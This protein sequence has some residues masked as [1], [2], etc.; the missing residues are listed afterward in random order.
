V[1]Q[2]DE[3]VLDVSAELHMGFPL[4]V[5]VDTKQSVRS[6]IPMQLTVVP[7]TGPAR[8]H[9]FMHHNTVEVC[10]HC[11]PVANGPPDQCRNVRCYDTSSGW[12]RVDLPFDFV[13]ESGEYTVILH[14]PG[15]GAR[16]SRTVRVPDALAAG[17]CALPDTLGRYRRAD[18][19]AAAV[20]LGVK[21]QY[22]GLKARYEA[23]HCRLNVFSLRISDAVR[24]VFV[25][26]LGRTATRSLP[27]GRVHQ[28]SLED[29][30]IGTWL[31]RESLIMVAAARDTPATDTVVSDLLRAYP[32][33]ATPPRQVPTCAATGAI[34]THAVTADSS[35]QIR[36][37]ATI[38]PFFDANTLVG[39]RLLSI[40]SGGFFH[41]A[42][43]KPNDVVFLVDDEP[44][45]SSEA[46]GRAI[47]RMSRPGRTSVVV[48][49][50]P[51]YRCLRLEIR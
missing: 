47:E 36:R 34:E 5:G 21:T 25:Q 28:V 15:T 10:P 11:D 45:A 3:L 48:G 30:W 27:E 44:L 16:L 26:G 32:P 9:E 6:P 31:G 35:Q 13:T 14:R 7:P 50:G 40:T 41:R 1:Y 37:K 23:G 33:P 20:P 4:R 18:C 51:G 49:Q 8:V 19:R 38:V 22:W 24:Y 42:G 43:F 12:T 46:L 39:M 17:G 29:G 2:S